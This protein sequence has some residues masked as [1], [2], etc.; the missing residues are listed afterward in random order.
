MIIFSLR[1][2]FFLFSLSITLVS[3]DLLFPYWLLVNSVLTSV[4]EETSM[5]V[6]WS[7]DRERWIVFFKPFI[8]NLFNNL[9]I[10]IQNVR[11]ILLVYCFA[12]LGC[13]QHILLETAD[14]NFIWDKLSINASQI[15]FIYVYRKLKKKNYFQ[16]NILRK[17]NRCKFHAQR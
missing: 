6:F 16:N 1:L 7:V 13:G 10:D 2:G 5:S 4:D 17:F 8:L 12:D 3:G 9:I 11:V 15:N 14:K